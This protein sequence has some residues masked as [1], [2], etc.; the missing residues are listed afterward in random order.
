MYGVFGELAAEQRR[1]KQPDSV[2]SDELEAEVFRNLSSQEQNEFYSMCR[3]LKIDKYDTELFRIMSLFQ[4][5]KRYLEDIP[6]EIEKHKKELEKFLEE[7]EKL[8]RQTRQS[9]EEID[10]HLSQV[11]ELN[12]QTQA[13]LQ[14]IQSQAKEVVGKTAGTL[15]REVRNG[16]D[17][18]KAGITAHFAGI[19]TEV[20]NT[21]KTM[22]NDIHATM[23]NIIAQM[24]ETLK[25]DIQK[26]L[27]VGEMEETNN[28]V[29][30]AIELRKEAVEALKAESAALVKEALA[31]KAERA[32]FEKERKQYRGDTVMTCWVNW[33]FSA[34]MLA[35]FIF[36]FWL[37]FHN[38]YVGQV[39]ESREMIIGQV[40]ENRAVLLEL[41]KTGHKIELGK[42]DKGRQQLF[43][44]NASGWT[45]PDKRG[46]INIR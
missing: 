12:S 15:H 7:T 24:K 22:R 38:R 3:K 4:Y 42:D 2:L 11:V 45:T 34:I 5:Q 14:S 20:N 46:V 35:G 17:N 31:L 19:N 39:A 44:R 8:A 9:S 1:E 13:P 40:D 25:A 28:A 37:F 16:L 18:I 33:R 30:K 10:R 6:S 36:S 41:A 23:D 32:A 43:V 27:K 26:A 29:S 21:L